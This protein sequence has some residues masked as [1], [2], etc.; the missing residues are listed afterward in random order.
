M[1]SESSLKQSILPPRNLP[2][3]L[4]EDNDQKIEAKGFP[5]G[6]LL[7]EKSDKR[8]VSKW[9]SYVKVICPLVNITLLY[10]APFSTQLSS[11]LVIDVMDILFKESECILKKSLIPY[12]RSQ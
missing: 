4:T 8:V 12:A 11:K 9:S 3:R 6:A 1:K 7:E 2:T 5:A 10:V